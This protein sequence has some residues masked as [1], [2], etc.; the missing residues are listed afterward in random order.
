MI[1][2]ITTHA[3]SAPK[4]TCAARET[5]NVTRRRR[6]RPR[7]FG[8]ERKMSLIRISLIDPSHTGRLSSWMCKMEAAFRGEHA[9][10]QWADLCRNAA[11][12]IQLF[13]SDLR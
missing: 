4:I 12:E 2:C 13:A 8:C 11:D 5:V 3:I 7:G 10:Q 9:G 6:A 1:E